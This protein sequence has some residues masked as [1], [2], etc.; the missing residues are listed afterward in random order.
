MSAHVWTVEWRT[1]PTRGWK[2]MSEGWTTNYRDACYD[3]RRLRDR[4]KHERLPYE[5]RVAKYVRV[6]WSK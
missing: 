3:L 1:K 2:P 6:E 4:S 5:Y